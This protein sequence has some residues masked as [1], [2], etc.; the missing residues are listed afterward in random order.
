[1]MDRAAQM[2]GARKKLPAY[3]KQLLAD[4]RAGRH[5]SILRVVYGDDWS[6]PGPKVCIRP[7]DYQPG[8]F[9]FSVAAGLYVELYDQADGL[10]DLDVHQRP[11]VFGAFYDLV[12][13]LVEAQACVEIR[14][15]SVTREAGE[16]AFTLRWW[17]AQARRFHWPRWWGDELAAGNRRRLEL[18][19]GDLR[20][21]TERERGART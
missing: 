6:V 21:F 1:M 13:E 7:A 17:D 2:H 15:A 18:C 5:P 10:C 19:L 14:A 16:L 9:D 4:R 3:G 12:R 11:P 8:V 20:Q